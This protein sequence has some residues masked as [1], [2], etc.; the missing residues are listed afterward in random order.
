[1]EKYLIK[2]CKLAS[3]YVKNKVDKIY[4]YCTRRK[5][6]YLTTAFFERNGRVV[7]DPQLNETLDLKDKLTLFKFD[8]TEKNK[9][10]YLYP[11]TD[12]FMDLCKENDKVR[13]LKIVYE[14]KSKKIDYVVSEKNIPF[15]VSDH[16]SFM[17]WYNEVKE[18][19]ENK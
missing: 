16:D 5:E 10:L 1:M 7:L 12:I 19:V 9:K 2:M 13:E 4:I 15:K 17:K 18:K 3:K 8:E 14:V 11:M 6:M